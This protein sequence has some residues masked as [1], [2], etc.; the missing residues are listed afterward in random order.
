MAN[1]K[2]LEA[3]FLNLGGGSEPRCVRS[4]RGPT[5]IG[6]RSDRGP[7]SQAW[8]PAGLRPKPF[9]GQIPRKESRS[10]Q[11][12]HRHIVSHLRS[13]PLR[14]E[15]VRNTP[16]PETDNVSCLVLK[17]SPMAGAHFCGLRSAAAANVRGSQTTLTSKTLT[18]NCREP[19]A[20]RVC[21]DLADLDV[22]RLR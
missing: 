9:R 10:E 12:R 22:R 21:W 6:P 18:A 17:S 15:P 11:N 13:Y 19:T 4:D 3:V 14:T 7:T 2:L 1:T 5:A 8:R 16:W 20:T